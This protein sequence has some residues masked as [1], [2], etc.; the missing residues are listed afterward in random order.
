MI[1]SRR[2]LLGA[3]AALPLA[4]CT[5]EEKPA[6]T[7]AVS[8]PATAPAGATAS[9]GPTASPSANPIRAE[10]V[11]LEKKYGAQLGVYVLATGTGTTIVH[12]ADTR[13]AFCS[14]FKGLAVGA[15]LHRKPMSYLDTVLRYTKA[16]L[17]KSTHE[18]TKAN[19]GNGMTVR[20]ACEMAVQHSDGTAGNLLLD[21]LGGPAELTAFLRSL[22]DQVTRSDRRE[23]DLTEAAPGDL[24]DTTTARAIGTDYQRLVLGQ[25][26]PDD[27][28]TILRELLVGNTTGGRRI[29]RGVPSGWRV[30]DKT[31]SGSYGTCNDIAIL[32]P[33]KGAAPLV[34]ALLSSMPK[35][36]AKFDENLLADATRF[37][38]RTL[39][40]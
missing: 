7:A 35:Q 1:I 5:T 2:A 28:R 29:R 12:R 31:G 15:I 39:T 40:A 26:L 3:A 13:F 25:D 33:P 8:S 4:G 38:V 6:T 30:A 21:A 16:D 14:T 18:W 23:P 10:L 9:A 24:R 22:D 32:W 20:K 17:L 37:V 11:T 27:K 34:V 19:V 36:G